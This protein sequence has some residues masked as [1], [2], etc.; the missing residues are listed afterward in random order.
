M[1][2]GVIRRCSRLKAGYLFLRQMR[3]AAGSTQQNPHV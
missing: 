3:I 2:A 1:T